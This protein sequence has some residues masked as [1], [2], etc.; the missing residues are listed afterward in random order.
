MLGTQRQITGRSKADIMEDGII[1]WEAHRAGAGGT[2]LPESCLA[3]FEYGW[4]LGGRPEADVNVTSDGVMVSLHDSTLD[5]IAR[6]LP[7]H[8]KGRPVS[9]ITWAELQTVDVGWDEFPDQHIT[10]L[11]TLF[12][13]LKDHPE[14]NMVIDYKRVKVSLLAEV[15]NR[16]GVASQ[17]T[18][19]SNDRGLLR[20]F[21][22]CAPAGR[23]KNWLGGPAE[24]IREKVAVLQ[25]ENFRGITEVQLHLN[26]APGQQWRY[27]LAP[28]FVAEALR[29]TGENGVLLQVLP[30]KFEKAD[31]DAILDLGV[32]S[33]AVDYPNKFKKICAVYFAGQVMKDQTGR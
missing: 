26:D 14:R 24:A 8:L 4:G 10:P 33:F 12:A 31:L 30:W 22:Q 1:L 28:E 16:F 3:A 25:Q 7:E 5:R 27:A 15:I 17:I 13:I 9:E 21:K 11:E 19:A 32:R 2:E 18:F 20:E 29:I 6:S 23:T